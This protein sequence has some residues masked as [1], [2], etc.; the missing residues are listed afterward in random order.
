MRRAN[1]FVFWSLSRGRNPQFPE[2]VLPTKIDL[3]TL[4]SRP[5][6]R[7]QMSKKMDKSRVVIDRKVP[8]TTHVR[9]GA[10]SKAATTRRATERQDPRTAA[11]RT[12]GHGSAMADPPAPTILVAV[13]STFRVLRTD[14]Q[15][16]ERG[17]VTIGQEFVKDQHYRVLMNAHGQIV[18]DPVVTIPA[19]ELWLFQNPEAWSSV[20]RGAAQAGRGELNSLGSFAKHSDDEVNSDD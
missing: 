14:I 16:D 1:F 3:A 19:R 13:D 12:T 5:T 17:R 18:L 2:W 10:S 15:P 11:E 7:K 20:L 9:K 4:R 8:A 6:E